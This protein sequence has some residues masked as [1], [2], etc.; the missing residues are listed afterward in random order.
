MQTVGCFPLHYAVCT[1]D[2]PIYQIISSA[3]LL[4]RVYE[5]GPNGRCSEPISSARLS[6]I[7]K[8]KSRDSNKT[9]LSSEFYN[10]QDTALWKHTR[11]LHT[12]RFYE[13]FL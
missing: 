3:I 9:K 1:V 7:S 12:F 13:F 2:G 8:T 4:L 5:P 6:H 11:A 10:V